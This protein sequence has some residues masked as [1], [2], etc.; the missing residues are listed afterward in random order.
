MREVRFG[1]LPGHSRRPKDNNL[2]SVPSTARRVCTALVLRKTP[3]RK[4]EVVLTTG[5][6]AQTLPVLTGNSNS[7]THEKRS[8]HLY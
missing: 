1:P 8:P 3:K 6:R 7:V 5:L 4:G 2:G